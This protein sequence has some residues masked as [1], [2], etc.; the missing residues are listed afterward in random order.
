[1]LARVRGPDESA[2]AKT[3]HSRCRAAGDPPA[4]LG[5]LRGAACEAA[6]QR[7]TRVGERVRRGPVRRRRLP[8]RARFL[9]RRHPRRV[10]H[11]GG[12]RS[13]A[14]RRRRR[15]ARRRTVRVRGAHLRGGRRTTRP[16]RSASPTKAGGTRATRRSHLVPVAFPWR[17]LPLTCTLVVTGALVLARRPGTRVARAFFLL[18][19]AYGLHWTFFFGGPRLQTYAW[20][21]VF[22][23]ASLVMLPLI[24]RAVL[25]FPAEVAPAGG[26]LPW[27]PWLFARLRADLARAGSSGFRCRRRWAFAP[28]SSSTSSS[29][30]PCSPSSPATSA[31]PARSA[32]ASSSGSSWACTSA[33]CRCCWPT[34]SP[35]S[36]RRC[37]GCTRLAVIAEIVIPLCVLI[38]IVRANYFDVD[39]L[40]TGTAVYS[41][42]SI[43]LLAA[44][45]IAVP[46]M[47]RVA[48]TRGRPRSAHR[49]ARAL[50][51]GR[52]RH[53]ARTPRSPSA[54]RARAVPRAPRAARRRGGPAAT[55]SRRPTAPRSCS[56][57]P[58]NVSM[59]SCGPQSCVIYAPLGERFTPVFARGTE[60]RGGPPTLSADAA[61]IVALRTRTAPLDV[62]QWTSADARRWRTTSAR[63]SSACAPPCFLPVRRGAD[64]AARRSASAPS[65]RATSTRPPTSRCSPRSP[66]R[67][68]ASC[69][70][71]TPPSSCVRSAR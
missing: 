30:P 52:R 18:A 38:A 2:N 47:A 62:E 40:I 50:G 23:C 57:W 20:V 32:G 9:A 39:R 71:S 34:S 44:V 4:A 8:D 29:S 26:R 69:C 22:F 14:D 24:L 7:P 58:A 54:H 15:S 28:S 48:S 3:A 49:P 43:L 27:W 64:L 10:R 21:V 66:T 13:L 11:A 1:M 37:G 56:R 5:R 19:I 51:R 6:R 25:I 68:P 53:R 60:R 41:L 65:A 45:L 35:P 16:A 17:M 12:R 46:Q 36:R 63:R 31:A 61:A 67:C 59:R 55:T 70:A 33:P 42:L